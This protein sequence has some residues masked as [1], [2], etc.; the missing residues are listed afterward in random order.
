MIPALD[1]VIESLGG[2][3]SSTGTFFI[4]NTVI[5]RD[6]LPAV[7]EPG[8]DASAPV[9]PRA[10]YAPKFGPREDGGRITPSR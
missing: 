7:R 2:N 9:V 4:Q 1:L 8:D 3:Y 6:L 5:P 10:D